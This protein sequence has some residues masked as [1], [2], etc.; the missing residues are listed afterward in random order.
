MQFRFTTRQ[1]LVTVGIASTL[2]GLNSFVDSRT[3]TF[4]SDLRSDPS[5]IIQ[6]HAE[7]TQYI[8]NSTLGNETTLLDRLCFRRRTAARYEKRWTQEDG[9]YTI[10][11][12][13]ITILTTLAGT[14]LESES[15]LLSL[16]H[17]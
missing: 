17:I 7:N 6:Q 3:R 15:K 16:I 11:Q 2:L 4:A 5:R 13:K 1:L 9:G 12:R 10:E 8:E 14:R